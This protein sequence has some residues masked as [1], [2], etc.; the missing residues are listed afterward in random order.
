MTPSELGLA[1][2]HDACTWY[3]AFW[4]SD[5]LYKELFGCSQQRAAEVMMDDTEMGDTLQCLN[6]AS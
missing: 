1:A 4:R 5:R 2:S 6:M 3:E